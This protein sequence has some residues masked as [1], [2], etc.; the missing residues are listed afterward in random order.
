MLTDLLD[1]A[2]CP[3]PM[4]GVGI[5]YVAKPREV[6]RLDLGGLELDVEVIHEHRLQTIDYPGTQLAGGDPTPEGAYRDPDPLRRLKYREH[7]R[8]GQ[9]LPYA[10]HAR[11]PRSQR[12]RLA[13]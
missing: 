8:K 7:L 13:V 12:R 5:A 11:G 4:S 9:I 6:A 3:P 2:R 1:A 10:E